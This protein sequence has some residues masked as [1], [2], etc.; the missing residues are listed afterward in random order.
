MNKFIYYFIQLLY[1]A[2]H[3]K[4]LLT[5]EAFQMLVFALVYVVVS[6]LQCLN[7]PL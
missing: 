1:S 5:Y 6:L 4:T 7:G 2:N 3:F